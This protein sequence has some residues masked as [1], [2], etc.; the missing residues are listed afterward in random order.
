MPYLKH[1]GGGDLILKSQDPL[2]K[3]LID[4]DTTLFIIIGGMGVGYL[5]N[6]PKKHNSI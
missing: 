5:P 6:H 3:L 1:N 4:T 2:S